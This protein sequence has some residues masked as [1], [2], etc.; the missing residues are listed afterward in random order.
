VIPDP[1]IRLRL[2]QLNDAFRPA[3]PVD[4][5]R[6]F[7][8][9][10]Q[11]RDR[12]AAAVATPG[13]HIAVF[14][15]RGVGKTSLAAVSVNA[16][17]DRG[18]IGMRINCSP[19]DDFQLVWDAVGDQLVEQRELGLIDPTWSDHVDGYLRIM[20]RDSTV[21]A[22][23]DRI[24]LALSRLS[25]ATRVLIFFDEYD[26]IE[27]EQVSRMMAST[28][29]TLSDHLV[30]ATVAVVG[31]GSDIADL[32]EG[33]QSVQ[34]CLEQLPMPR[35]SEG[36]TTAIVQRGLLELN[37]DVVPAVMTLIVRTAQGL[38]QYAHLMGRAF[39]RSAIRRSAHRIDA[40]DVAGA[41]EDAVAGVEQSIRAQYN[42]ATFS[43][44]S[45]AIYKQ[46]LLSCAMAALDSENYFAPR[47]LA[48]TL[49]QLLGR[50]VASD[51]YNKHLVEFCDARG[52][53]L[54][55][56]GSRNRWRYRF[57]DPA[58]PPYVLL[59]A[60]IDGLIKFTEASDP[61]TSPGDGQASMF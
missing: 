58:M 51:T 42:S 11:Q 18:Y 16:A 61:G 59:L 41:L 36:E 27:D 31:V 20:G 3:G 39:A 40:S 22:E 21:L 53:V 23:P 57:A 47:D 12:V 56:T 33:H 1:E 19:D 29:K 30:N 44:N 52:P 4:Q 60:R 5:E 25:Q 34:R 35:M 38:P 7:M 14:G 17:R 45:K 54:E 50:A 24:R 49:G 6:L 46:V 13:Q 48:R 32:I 8:G 28:I 55:R 26:Q 37:L 10:E 9:R 2:D 43:P 15:E